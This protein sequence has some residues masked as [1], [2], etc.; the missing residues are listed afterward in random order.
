MDK[1]LKNGEKLV[2]IGAGE[3]AEI[4]YEYFTYDSPYEVVAFSADKDHIKNDNLYDLPV[5][6][7]EDVHQ[8]YPV[9]EYKAFVAVPY[10]NFN[11][12]RTR[13]YHEAKNKGYNL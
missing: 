4:A 5:V 1:P 11:R 3:L 10:S 13:F 12:L 7:F 9:T 8:I 6:P 2:I